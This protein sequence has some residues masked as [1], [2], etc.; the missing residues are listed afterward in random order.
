MS[1]RYVI[2][3]AGPAGIRAAQILV[4]AGI[5]PVVIDEASRSGGQIY[6]RQPSGFTRSYSALYGSEAVKAQAV[7][8]AA[9]RVLAQCDYRPDTL[10]WAIY[11]KQVHVT[12]HGRAEV[13]EYDRLLIAAGAT[14][15]LL[16]LP[17]WT[18]PGTFTLGGAQIA[19][20]AQGCAIGSKVAFVGTGP[21]LYLVAFQYA[22]AGANL[23]GVFDTTPALTRLKGVVGLAARPR[24]LALGL[25]YALRLCLKGVSLKTG[26]VPVAIEG[27]D[28]VRALRYRDASGNERHVD[29]DAVGMGY[30][31]RAEAQLADLARCRFAYSEQHRQWLPEVDSDGRTSVPGVYMAG[32]CV[33]LLGADGAEIS[34]RLAAYA[35]LV[36]ERQPIP[37][38][39]VHALRSA[40]QVME[41]FQR[42]V[43]AAFP[44]PVANLKSLPDDTLICRC[45]AI[46]VGTLKA[47]LA[48]GNA[49]EA[50]RA[51]ALTRVGMG[52]CQ[53]RFC[54]I[55]G[56]ELMAQCLGVSP[57]E[58]GRLRAAAPIKQLPLGTDQESR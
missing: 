49:P 34:G 55:A 33:R 10:A 21:L 44:L 37:Q 56:A 38:A 41:R 26:V 1:A 45:E 13:V 25:Y 31:L 17:G 40:Q 47:T 23:V 3:G 42:G 29:C 14:D 7:H 2:I 54:A 58:A 11:D 28:T 20:K 12:T 15:R 46:T 5:R 8:D 57:C 6:R 51:K 18:T 32:D 9:D 48:S 43:A 22:K 24:L 52:R 53:G 30:H 39:N 36:D 4:E 35:A 27:G 16:P 50:N 19:L